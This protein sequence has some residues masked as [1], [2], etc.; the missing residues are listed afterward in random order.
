[1]LKNIFEGN[2]RRERREVKKKSERKELPKGPVGLFKVSDLNL[3]SKT[4]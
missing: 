1:M 3:S 4:S 2:E